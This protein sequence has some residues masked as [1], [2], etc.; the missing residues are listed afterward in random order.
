MLL[1]MLIM[2]EIGQSLAAEQESPTGV[3]FLGTTHKGISASGASTIHSFGVDSDDPWALTDYSRALISSMDSKVADVAVGIPSQSLTED[4][5]NFGFIEIKELN[6]HVSSWGASANNISSFKVYTTINLSW[7]HV[8]HDMRTRFAS[9]KI[10]EVRFVVS[11]FLVNSRSVG[12]QPE[13]QKLAEYIKEDFDNAVRNLMVKVAE[14][15][16]RMVSRRITDVIYISV[17]LPAVSSRTQAA[18]REHYGHLDETLFIETLRDSFAVFLED[19]LMEVFQSNSDYDPFVLL[20]NPE[21][22]DAVLQEWPIFAQRVAAASL[23]NGIL[24]DIPQLLKVSP[25][26]GLTRQRGVE[27]PGFEVRSSLAGLRVDRYPQNPRV[28]LYIQDVHVAGDVRLELTPQ[29]AL[30][31]FNEARDPVLQSFSWEGSKSERTPESEFLAP[32]IIPMQI[33]NAIELFATDIAE[34]LLQAKTDIPNPTSPS[35]LMENCQ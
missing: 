5:Y 17:A 2:G 24:R 33:A 19:E 32:H 28:D 18:I 25:V 4:P 11:E 22:A 21:F 23:Y 9:Q 1:C 8:G 26:C 20:P 29:E 14:Q 13:E 12:Q 31:P 16:T 27:V 7:V 15:H 34:R 6:H 30:Q 3:Y 35:F 10:P